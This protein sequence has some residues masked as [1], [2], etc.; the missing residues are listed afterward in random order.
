MGKGQVWVNGHNLGRYWT[1]SAPA[2]GCQ[3][4][5][6]RGAYDSN[7]CLT[8]CG[9]PTQSW[10]YSYQKFLCQLYIQIVTFG[11]LSGYPVTASVKHNDQGLIY[12]PRN[13]L[14]FECFVIA[15]VTYY[16]LFVYRYHIPRSWLQPSNN[17]LVI[18]EETE[19]NPF[20]ISIKTHFTETICGK[21]SEDHFPPL[22]AWSPPETRNGTLL[23]KYES[24]EMYLHCDTRN[25]ISSIKFA[26][27]GTPH[28]SCQNFSRG[29]CH[30]ANSY[31]VLSQ[32][33]IT[34]ILFHS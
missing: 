6:Y 10:Y 4:C 26:S 1:L 30:A 21:V 18:F 5:D 11:G 33:C 3:T 20:E 13:Y 2:D 28:G 17:V 22:H 8:N 14:K 19:K 34:I 27:Y 12:E 24:P 29:N 32:V 15:I 9:E 16:F 25:T 7:K 23:L 31:S